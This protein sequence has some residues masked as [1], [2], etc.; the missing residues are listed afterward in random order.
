VPRPCGGST[1]CTCV[2]SRANTARCGLVARARRPVRCPDHADPADATGGHSPRATAP[3]RDG[4]ERARPPSRHPRDP[5]DSSSGRPVTHGIRPKHARPWRLGAP[6]SI[7]RSTGSTVTIDH[8]GLRYPGSSRT[9][10]HSL[11]STSSGGGEQVHPG[12][13][14]E[15]RRTRLPTHA[16]WLRTPDAS[17]HQ[18]SVPRGA[19]QACGWPVVAAMCS[20]SAS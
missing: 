1:A 4:V 20:K 9:R 17:T 10:S 5:R 6:P 8:V 16:S 19:I 13:L 2:A 7:T 11:S 12:C 3:T 18:G 14:G 15:P